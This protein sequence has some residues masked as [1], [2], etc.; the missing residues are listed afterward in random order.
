MHA[1]IPGILRELSELLRSAGTQ[2]ATQA[3]ELINKELG[4]VWAEFITPNEVLRVGEGEDAAPQSTDEG[5]FWSASVGTG[6]LVLRF[7]DQP[8]PELDSDMALVIP[9]LQLLLE[10]PHDLVQEQYKALRILAETGIQ[11]GMDTFQER[12]DALAE[13]LGVRWVYIGRLVENGEIE[14]FATHGLPAFHYHPQDTPCQE[15]VNHG[16]RYYP[17]NIEEM[18]PNNTWLA[19]LGATAYL[20]APLRDSSGRFLGVMA[21][22]HDQALPAGREEFY[23]WVF[24]TFASRV[25][26]ALEKEDL[27]ARFSAA[28]GANQA[29]ATLTRAEDIYR[30]AVSQ[31]LT[32]I[33]A[34]AAMLLVYDHQ[35]GSLK[36]VGFESE[37]KTD[38]LGQ[39]LPPG[40]GHADPF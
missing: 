3:L 15:V 21:A 7:K 8:P 6:T 36:L 14:A 5:S 24:D 34:I 29:L 32:H 40:S 35:E 9:M 4:A 37:Q 31:T 26:A 22:L 12:A 39:V 2:V 18:F 11:V 38:M 33:K 27:I 28:A 17:K 20:G 1:R 16:F 10:P 19:Q 30:Q 25:A 23:R 13:A